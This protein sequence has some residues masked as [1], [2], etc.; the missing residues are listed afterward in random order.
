MLEEDDPEGSS[1]ISPNIND[2]SGW[3]CRCARRTTTRRIS[4]TDYRIRGI[5]TGG[6][7]LF[8]RRLRR[9]TAIGV[10]LRHPD[11]R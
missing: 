3:M 6:R 7:W 5:M 9:P 2:V 11:R 8:Q 1:T 4:R 10:L